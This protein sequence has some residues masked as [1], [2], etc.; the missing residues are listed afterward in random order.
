ML[1]LAVALFGAA[2]AVL[3]GLATANNPTVTAGPNLSYNPASVTIAPGAMVDFSEA[4]TY[5]HDVH[6]TGPEPWSCTGSTTQIGPSGSDST[7]PTVSN[8][9]WTGTCTFTQAGTYTF[10]CDLH[11]FTG[12]IYVGTSPPTTTG[13]TTT[14]TTTGTTPTTTTPGYPS[15]TVTGSTPT[16]SGPTGGNAA[17]S[18][19][20]LPAV[21]HGT[22]VK[23]TVTIA[24]GGSDFEADLLGST[25][26][27]ARSTV[28]GK[29]VKHGVGAGTLHFRV[30][31][32]KRGRAALKRHRRLAL[33]LVV[34]VRGP[35]GARSSLSRSITLR[36]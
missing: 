11:N 1:L 5:K 6:F 22:T 20:Q 24:S 4:G 13:T 18:S 31:L 7:L 19:L 3:P 35:G 28:V 29:T 36:S 10:K 14:T 23:G 30:T 17:A 12:T 34:T 33:K 8:S 27:L 21:Q 16:P 9:S 25:S 2:I 15:P 26:Q 32:N